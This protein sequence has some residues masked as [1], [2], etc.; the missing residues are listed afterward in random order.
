MLSDLIL[1]LKRKGNPSGIAVSF[2]PELGSD[3]IQ[4]NV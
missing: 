3:F 2:S 4:K 1:N